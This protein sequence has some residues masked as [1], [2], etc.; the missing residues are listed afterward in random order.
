MR[1]DLHHVH[2]FASELDESLRFYRDLFGAEIVFDEIVAGVRNVLVR[3]GTGH[4]NFYDQPPRETGKNAVHHLGILTDDLAALV[5]H[6]QEKGFP[7]RSPVRDFGDLKYI[8]LE[9][10]DRVLIEVFEKKAPA[11]GDTG[12]GSSGG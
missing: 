6:M 11:P 3:I 1:C 9:G 2:L 5:A 12:P 10:P 7:C 4:I 8:M